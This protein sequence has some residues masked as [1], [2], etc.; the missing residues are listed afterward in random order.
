MIRFLISAF[1]N[2]LLLLLLGV[3]LI[4]LIVLSTALL[5]LQSHFLMDQASRS[6]EAVRTI[7][8]NQV[9]SYFET[10]H[11]QIVTFSED[12]MV[13]TA[14]RSFR[15]ASENAREETETSPEQLEQYRKQ[16][17]GFYETDFSQEY[18]DQNGTEPPIDALFSSLDDDAVYFQYQ[19][20][21]ANPNPLGAKG[22]LDAASDGSTYAELH[23]RF[24]PAIRSYQTKFDYYDIFLV[25]IESGDVVYSVFKEIDYMTSLKTGA[26]A[27]SSIGTVFSQAATALSKDT[28]AFADYQH[29]LPSYGAP[30]SF[31][32]SPIFDEAQEAI[33]VAIFQMPVGRINAIMSERTGLGETGETYA[34][35]DDHLFRNDSNFLADFG[36]T[37]TIINPEIT[38]DT[39]ASRSALGKT[40]GGMSDTRIVTDHRGT[41]VL[42]SWE[43]ITVHK[44]SRGLGR[45]V[46]WALISEVTLAEIQSP[47]ATLKRY[48]LSILA[49]ATILVLFV[50]WLFAVRFNRESERQSR[51]IGGIADNT[52][53]LASAS[54]E[55]TSVSHQL[56]SN[57]EETTSQANLVS[58]AAEQVSVNSQTV[59]N[60]VENLSSSIREIAQSANEAAKVANESVR[61]AQDA[62]S[63]INKLGASS[64]EIGDVLKVITTIADQTKLLALNAT[65]EAARAG[66]AGKGFAVVA[67]EVKDLARETS[68]ATEDIQRW[69]V[70][71]RGDATKAVSSIASISEIIGRISGL[72][73]TIA[74]AV[75]QQT[76][77]TIEISRNVAEAATGSAEIARNITQ[78][79]NAS[80]STAEGA[81]NTQ[82]ASQ[83][84]ARMS[85]DL[86]Q[87]VVEYQ[88]E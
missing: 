44:A 15:E 46:R 43:P 37:T 80:Q 8:A 5:Y 73:N 40:G 87:L 39:A 11:D 83:E 32:A 84:L 30:A 70:V 78:V 62:D 75:D 2:R 24:H 33:G 52:Q 10:I 25:D 6:L 59:S 68:R 26:H 34:V 65:I 74:S 51:L 17:R 81:G 77:T 35:G 45:D 76:S 55:L 69:I 28:I 7:K 57:A 3:S 79:A 86:Q 72:Q 4:P 82:V 42:S 88:T 12:P 29:Y 20:I 60:G 61:L 48:A 41:P 22:T 71:I 21:K 49:V 85:A 58:V 64:E 31:I 23:S 16:V 56:S 47:I 9:E 19:Y 63:T 66:E 67:N 36:V 18:I 38:V 13:I 50:S 54:E 53:T 27:N 1:Q 14:M